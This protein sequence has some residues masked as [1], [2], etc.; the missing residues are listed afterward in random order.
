MARALAFEQRLES[1]LELVVFVGKL[2]VEA[3]RQPPRYLRERTKPGERREL[4]RHG[5]LFQFVHE[6]HR[7]EPARDERRRCL[8][9][10]LGVRQAKSPP[11]RTEP[12]SRLKELEQ[13]VSVLG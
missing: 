5:G 6:L 10:D 8:R 11:G 1:P 7:H 4:R 13:L 12:E 2:R 3:C 9:T